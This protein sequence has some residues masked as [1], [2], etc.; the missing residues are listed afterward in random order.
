MTGPGRNDT[1][2][3]YINRKLY[4]AMNVCPNCYRALPENG[5][6]CNFC[7]TD[8]LQY[9]FSAYQQMAYICQQYY[10]YF[11]Y[12][13]YQRYMSQFG[14]RYLRDGREGTGSGEGRGGT[15]RPVRDQA[16]FPRP[17]T[18]PGRNAGGTSYYQPRERLAL[19]SGRSNPGEEGHD[20]SYQYEEEELRDSGYTVTDEGGSG[21]E[22]GKGEPLAETACFNCG[23]DIPIYT[24]ERPLYVTCPNCGTEGEIE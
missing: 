15:R 5:R 21:G 11:Q 17:G 16:P 4:Q 13:Q 18:E 9:Y 7:N 24:D 6:I 22:A 10:Q 20:F 8:A 2:N 3:I 12:L 23:K 19:P 1:E 14:P